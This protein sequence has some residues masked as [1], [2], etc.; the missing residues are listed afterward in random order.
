MG[1][2]SSLQITACNNWFYVG[3]ARQKAAFIFR[4]FPADIGLPSFAA[5]LL[6][7]FN[8][9]VMFRWFSNLKLIGINNVELTISVYE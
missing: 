4:L 3:G 8:L 1:G 7:N 9:G 6:C 2:V 5:P